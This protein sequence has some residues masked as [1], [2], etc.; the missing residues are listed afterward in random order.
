M[1]IVIM[2]VAGSGKTKA[3]EAL[4]SDLERRIEVTLRGSA[5]ESNRAGAHVWR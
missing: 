1:I 3:G 5:D 4:A 2:G